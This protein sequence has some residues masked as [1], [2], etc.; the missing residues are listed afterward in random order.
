VTRVVQAVGGGQLI[1]S[2]FPVARHSWQCCKEQCWTDVSIVS[3]GA[4][5]A[6]LVLPGGA[7]LRVR[8]AA[9]H[10]HA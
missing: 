4:L 9:P 5:H 7:K 10:I 2:R 8:P 6:E 3:R 1:L